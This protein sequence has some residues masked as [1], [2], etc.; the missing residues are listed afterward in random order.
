MKITRTDKILIPIVVLFL[1]FWY[2]YSNYFT[3]NM[4]TGTYVKIGK[5]EYRSFH[6][7]IITDTLFLFEDGHFKEKKIRNVVDKEGTYE[8]LNEL[9]GTQ[10]AFSYYEKI[11]PDGKIGL[12]GHDSYFTRIWFSH[13]RIVIDNDLDIYYEKI[14]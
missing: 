9:L 6:G 8:L 12:V 11:S 3:Q 7:N 2:G 14:D 5:P 13:I 10:I 4:I 1:L